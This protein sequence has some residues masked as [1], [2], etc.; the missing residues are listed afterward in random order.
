MAQLVFSNGKQQTVGYNQAAK[1]LQVLKGEVEPE[2]EQQ[3]EFCATVKDVV[4]PEV[5]KS[6][7]IKPREGK[8]EKLAAIMADP[9]LRG[10]AKYEAVKKHLQGRLLA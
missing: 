1:I 10:Y 8:D 4:F 9:K 7:Q 6:Y 2:N 3:A 5:K